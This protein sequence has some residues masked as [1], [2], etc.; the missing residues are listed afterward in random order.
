MKE[1][2]E[3]CFDAGS[4]W[5]KAMSNMSYD[6]SF[7]EW[8]QQNNVNIDNYIEQYL[9]D[10]YPTLHQSFV[11][12]KLAKQYDIKVV[13]KGEGNE[14]EFIEQLKQILIVSNHPIGSTYIP[15]NQPQPHNKW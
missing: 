9:K 14:E 6:I 13:P 4:D 2:L 15:V 1:L 12:A 8:Y 5:Y 3:N 11:V 10:N 7:E